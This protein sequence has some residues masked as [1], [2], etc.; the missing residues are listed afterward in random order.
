M[1][2]KKILFPTAFSTA[3]DAALEMGDYEAAFEHYQKMMDLRPNLAS[4]S[5]GAHLL[6]LTGDV[7]KATWLMGWQSMPAPKGLAI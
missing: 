1:T 2:A 6:Y 5:R 4:Y 7:R 3:S